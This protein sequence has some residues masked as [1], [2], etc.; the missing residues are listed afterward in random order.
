MSSEFTRQSMEVDR[1]AKAYQRDHG[2]DYSTALHAI[3]HQASYGHQQQV[4]RATARYQQEHGGNVPDGWRIYED[5]T[6]TI[7]EIELKDAGRAI[8][9]LGNV[10]CNLPRLSDGT[11]DIQP[12]RAGTYKVG[13]A[14]KGC[15][16][17]KRF[18]ITERR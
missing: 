9:Q 18:G 8:T 16:S 12:S 15:K 4:S 17:R 10:I 7:L 2:C 13:F 5:N 1:L 11:I 6:G 3:V 14:S